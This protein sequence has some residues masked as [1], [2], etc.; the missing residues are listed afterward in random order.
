[1][2]SSSLESIAASVVPENVEW[3]ILVVDNNSAD[4]TREVVED[5][6]RRHAGRFRYLL[7]PQQGLSFARNAG[8]RESRGEIVAFTDDD[9][10]VEP[11][12][13]WNLTA[14]L[15]SGEWAG[16]AGRIIPTWSQP[17]PDWMVLENPSLAGFIVAFDLGPNA[18]PLTRPPFGANMAFRRE[19]FEIYG[20]F[21]TDLGRSGTV[22]L[23][24]EE[25]EFCARLFAGGEH[26]R[27]TPSSVVYH[28][29]P[30]ERMR[31]SYLL[32]WSFGYAVSEVLA[33]G[34]PTIGRWRVLGVPLRLFRG[35]AKWSVQWGV[36]LGELRR[37][38][39]RR[40][41]SSAA[42]T[43]VGCYQW[44]RARRT[45]TKPMIMNLEGNSKGDSFGTNSES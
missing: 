35:L 15:Q 3:E 14:T 7:E 33:S 27:Y 37:F 13:L 23:C 26:L 45:Q 38:E 30:E 17:K 5:F 20:G 1:L 10:V 41:L 39:C 28:P 36:S 4:R 16:A 44:W 24:G 19:V 22:L 34:P 42:G 6:S 12:W 31:K 9:V 29:V 32:A 25:T 11:T 8:V 43:I 18:S 2:L 40:N 21:R